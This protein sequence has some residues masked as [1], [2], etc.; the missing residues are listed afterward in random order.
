MTDAPY[1]SMNCRNCG[2]NLVR[3]V[4][5]GNAGRPWFRVECDHCGSQQS[6]GAAPG[7][8]TIPNGVSY[9]SVNCRCPS[10]RQVNPKVERTMG[11]IRYHKC[12]NCG[13]QFKSVEPVSTR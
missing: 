6:V 12:Q 11:R 7:V 5:A 2:C 8:P 3:L 13:R 9:N 10:C 4:G 1:V